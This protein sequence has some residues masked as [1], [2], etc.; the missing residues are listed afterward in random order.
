[1]SEQPY[2]RLWVADFLGDTLHL[3]DAEVGQYMLLLMAMWRNGGSLPDDDAV[4]A[5]IARA[6]VSPN[7][8]SFFERICGRNADALLTQKRLAEELRAAQRRSEAAALSAKAKWLKTKKRGHADAYADA[9]RTDMPSQCVRNA[10]HSQ[11]ESPNG[12]SNNSGDTPLSILKTVLDG[13]HA[14]AVVDYRKRKKEPLNVI[15]AK[16][17][18]AQLARWPDPNAAAAE[19]MLRN[20]RGFKPEWMDEDR[21]RSGRAPPLA[22]HERYRAET[23]RIFEEMEREA[24]ERSGNSPPPANAG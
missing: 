24:D 23:Q 7:V 8:R 14:Q 13:E 2:M 4:L 5:R 1:M 17:L 16:R 9:E 19:M 11:I 3:T 12:D 10:N 18:A 15:A 20:W 6:P 21:R 22:P